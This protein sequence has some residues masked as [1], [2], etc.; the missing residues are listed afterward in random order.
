MPFKNQ[1][2]SFS[3]ISRYEQCPLS[4]ELHYIDH[5]EAEPGPALRFGKIIHAVLEG[6]LADVIQNEQSGPLSEARAIELLRWSWSSDG[7]IGIELFQEAVEILKAFVRD[8]GPVDHHD[9]LAVEKEFE[10]RTGPFTVVGFMDRVDRVDD[11]TVE[12]IDY[13]TNRMV[14]SREEVENSLQL[15]LYH[16]AAQRIWPWAKKVKLTFHLLRHGIRMGTE[17]TR[18]QLDA[19]L[20]YV[21]TIGNMTEEATEFPP[22]LNTNC[23][24]CDHHQRCPAYADAL[25]G[26]R[27]FICEDIEDLEAVAREREEVARLAKI[28]YTRK[29]ELEGVLK[30]HLQ[31]QDELSLAGVT[32]RMFRTSKVEYPVDATLKTLANATGLSRDD[33]VGSLASIEKKAMDAFL[34]ELAGSLDKPRLNLLKA[35]LEA[36][37]TRTWSTRFWAKEES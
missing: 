1:H 6:L 33:L 36:G 32:Y 26:K 13:K 18:E 8:Q 17:R 15:S 31:E 5:E 12:V 10:I 14:F 24:W 20:A 35:E 23:V 11:E 29:S 22:R 2:L 34:K 3:R 25:K 37:A 28:L 19:A 27:D 4:F 21:Q 30:A 9:V 7:L 16:L